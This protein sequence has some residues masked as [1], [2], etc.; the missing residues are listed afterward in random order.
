V[1][2]KRSASEED[3]NDAVNQLCYYLRMIL[4]EQLDRRFVMGLVVCFDQ[5]SV[6]LNDR[7][8]LLGTSTVIN[9]HK[10]RRRLFSRVCHQSNDSEPP[11]LHPSDCCV[12]IS[13]RSEYRVGSV[14][15]G[16]R[17]RKRSIL[18]VI[19]N[20]QPTRNL[21]KEYLFDALGGRCPCQGS[22]TA[23]E[24]DHRTCALRRWS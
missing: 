19:S 15:E 1:E 17:S 2:F 5:V 13:R 16:L 10:V 20:W 7:S 3:F 18:S 8:G 12:R 21:R 24:S 14:H 9:I 11:R 4:R 22:E 23:G 6:L